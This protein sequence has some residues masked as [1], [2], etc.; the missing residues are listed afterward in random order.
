MKTIKRLLIYFEIIVLL[1]VFIFGLCADLPFFGTLA[2]LI[3]PVAYGV[4]FN[5]KGHLE[6]LEK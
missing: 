2:C 5:V 3:G 6:S 4:I 1:A